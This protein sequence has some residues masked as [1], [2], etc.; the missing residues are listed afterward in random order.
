MVSAGSLDEVLVAFGNARADL[1]K[2]EAEASDLYEA[3]TTCQRRMREKRA[4]VSRL[5]SEVLSYLPDVAE[6]LKEGDS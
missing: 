5:R 1:Q 6:R 3:L 4:L 2:I